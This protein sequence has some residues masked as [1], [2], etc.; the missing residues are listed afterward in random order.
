M[1]ALSS[2]IYPLF[3][4]FPPPFSIKSSFNTQRVCRHEEEEIQTCHYFPSHV[5]G[6]EGGTGENVQVRP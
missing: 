2:G 6:A 1:N 5:V 3:Y 4:H